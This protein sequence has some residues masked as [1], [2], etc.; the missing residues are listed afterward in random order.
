VS[1]RKQWAYFLGSLV[2]VAIGVLMAT[3]GHGSERHGGI[4]VALFFGAGVIVLLPLKPVAGD[5]A[6]KLRT[7]GGE[8]AFEVTWPPGRTIRMAMAV[9]ARSCFHATPHSCVSSQSSAG[10]HTPPRCWFSS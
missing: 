7:I 8:P 3:R 4:Y 10:C 6:I 2:F 1:G 9:N 5:A